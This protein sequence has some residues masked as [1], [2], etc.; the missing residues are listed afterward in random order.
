MQEPDSPFSKAELRGKLLAQM[1][2]IARERRAFSASELL[3]C[4]ESL[5]PV[6]GWVVSFQSLP[7]EPD[8]TSLNQ[9]LFERHQ[10]A[11]IDWSANPPLLVRAQ[12]PTRSLDWQIAPDGEPLSPDRVSL[13]LVPAVAFSVRGDR[14]GRG[15]GAYDRLLTALPEAD[16]LGIGWRGMEQQILPTD[17]WDRPVRRRLLLG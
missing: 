5:G 11:W 1:R 12:D 16:T 6:S 17:P 9:L 4:W 8:L 13:I 3:N 7:D 15:F 14:L 2:S 10:L